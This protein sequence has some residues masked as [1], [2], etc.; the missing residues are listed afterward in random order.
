MITTSAS[1]F[2]LEQGSQN[3]FNGC[4][5][6]CEPTYLELRS[7]FSVRLRII[8]SVSSNEISSGFLEVT[9]TEVDAETGSGTGETALWFSAL[10]EAV[11]AKLEAISDNS[12]V[13]FTVV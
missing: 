3:E 9:K 11:V 10:Q 5:V 1:A 12:G 13:T 2:V 8:D 6:I 4:S 7:A